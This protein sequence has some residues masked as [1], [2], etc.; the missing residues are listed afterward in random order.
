MVIQFLIYLHASM[1][2]PKIN[3]KVSMSNE[4][5]N[6]THTYIHTYKQETEQCNL[7]DSYNNKNSVS[8]NLST[9]MLCEKKNIHT[10][11]INT[12]ETV[13]FEP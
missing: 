8:A 7:Y 2:R 12:G 1:N 13:V 5:N 11:T 6:Q 4:G 10:F 9:I 3:Y